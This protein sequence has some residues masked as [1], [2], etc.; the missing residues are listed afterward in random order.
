[1][2]V[3]AITGPLAGPVGRVVSWI[4]KPQPATPEEINSARNNL[5]AALS[6]AWGEKGSEVYEYLPMRVKFT[7]WSDD[8]G[9]QGPHDATDTDAPAEEQSQAGDFDSVADAFS[10][11]PRY[12]RVV[13]DEAGAGKTVLVTE[14]QRK[15]VEA[16]KPGD[17]VPVIVPA[18]AWRPDRQSL[19][20]WLGE[21]LA[22]D[23]GWL[24]VAHARA[25]VA[26]GMVL[27]ILDGLGEMP[28]SLRPVAIAR[29]NKHHMYRP[30]VVTSHEEEYRTAARQN[31]AAVKGSVAV[32]M[33]PLLP[34]DT[35][36][37]LDPTNS[38]G[39]AD[40][41][42]DTDAHAGELA[43]VLANPLML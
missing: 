41:L 29:I 11:E 31:H 20:D 23:Y 6:G 10:L 33:Q 15:L 27:P 4:R 19:L 21:R 16:P 1:V 8:A 17:P 12:R 37:Y 39:W 38:G 30:L 3:L 2:V 22:A 26:R 7:P 9:S 36:S 35:L 25:L 28:R 40:V 42:G 34:E 5:Q 13:L 32:V 24:P 14:L 18:A 43:R